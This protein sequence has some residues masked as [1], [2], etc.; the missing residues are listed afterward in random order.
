MV[1]DT[2]I[3][4]YDVVA[5]V[6]SIRSHGIASL[7][8]LLWDLL[9]T[10]DDEVR[11]IWSMKKGHFK[12]LHMFLRYFILSAQI[13]HQ[14]IFPDLSGDDTISPLGC[15][16]WHA[17][18][19][20][21]FR[22][23]IIAFELV[24]AF[25]VAALFGG[26]RWVSGLLGSVMAVEIVCAIPDMWTYI[27]HYR[28]CILFSVSQEA[29]VQGVAAVV[30]HTTIICL[31]LCRVFLGT[32]FLKKTVAFQI[33]RDGSIAYLVLI[34]LTCCGFIMI[35]SHGQPAILFFWGLTV[36]SICGTRLILNMVR[37]VSQEVPQ[38]SENILFTTQ[39]DVSIIFT[40]EDVV[41]HQPS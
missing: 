3:G 21:V 15:K 2:I 36:L 25:R 13:F 6:R 40:P 20:V 19:I 39:I 9:L 29:Q 31:T 28:Y 24:L 27:R 7:V 11:W 23:T 12:C 17:Y 1:S 38:G 22:V 14:I 18:M 32:G 26:R 8:V 34:G 33:A 16:L 35:K 30:V 4:Q 41:N 10:M 37:L 5:A